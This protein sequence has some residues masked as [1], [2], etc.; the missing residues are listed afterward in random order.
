MTFFRSVPLP[1]YTDVLRR[2]IQIE[3]EEPYFAVTENGQ[4]DSLLT[5]A[6]LQQCKQGLFAI[7][8]AT[9]PF[10]HKIRA[11]CSSALYFGQPEFAHRYYRKLILS[12]DFNP[13]WLQAKGVYPFSIYSL[14]SPT[15]VTKIFNLELSHTDIFTEGTHCQ[16]Y[17]E[18]IILLPVTDGYTNVS[19][20]GSRV[21][22][23]HLPELISPQEHDQIKHDEARTHRALAAL[24]TIARRSSPANQQS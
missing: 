5:M 15:I 7:C 22:P 6:D 10:I 18:A 17:T 19:L 12:K 21:L 2:H 4:Y 16:F 3:P 8:E 20:S 13:L 24:E 23:P 14:S 11:S 1:A 9:F